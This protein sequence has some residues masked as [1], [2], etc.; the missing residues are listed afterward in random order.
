MNKGVECLEICLLGSRI[1]RQPNAVKHAIS[2]EVKKQHLEHHPANCSTSSVL[3][4][5]GLYDSSSQAPF[6]THTATSDSQ[7]PDMP[8]TAPQG[9]PM[10]LVTHGH[11]GGPAPSAAG[12]PNFSPFNFS[13]KDFE[14]Q[15][16]SMKLQTLHN[17]HPILRA[18]GRGQ[19]FFESSV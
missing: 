11:C 19:E 14:L 6:F 1:G 13:N 5:A 8:F 4:P 9:V 3:P 17:N 2:L 18:P 7:L 10:H 15:E 16:V 12:S